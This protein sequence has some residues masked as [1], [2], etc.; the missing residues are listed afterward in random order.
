M[1]HN[2]DVTFD[3][4]SLYGNSRP[5]SEGH[6]L[7]ETKKSVD[8]LGYD[9]E[10]TMLQQLQFSFEGMIP[11]TSADGFDGGE[12]KYVLDLKVLKEQFEKS[13]I[14]KKNPSLYEMICW[15][16]KINEQAGIKTISF[17]DFM[18]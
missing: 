18:Q 12:K 13:H 14:D 4:G 7:D 9:I 3:E 17:D 5:V 10:F 8:S 2:A 6:G 1:M 16:N 11:D 15:M